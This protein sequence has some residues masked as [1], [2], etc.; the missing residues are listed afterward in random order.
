MKTTFFKIATVM[1][2]LI[3]GCSKDDLI[4]NEQ[5]SFSVEENN[6][7]VIYGE[8]GAISGDYSRG[9]IISFGGT[10][11]GTETLPVCPPGDLN[12]VRKLLINGNFSGNMKRFGKIVPSLSTYEISWVPEL[13]PLF[14]LENCNCPLEEEYRYKLVAHGRVALSDKDYF[15]ITIEGYL[16]TYETRTYRRWTYGSQFS[17]KASVDEGSGVGKFINFSEEFAVLTTS[18]SRTNFYHANLDTGVISFSISN[19]GQ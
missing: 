8:K 4:D 18:I 15:N 19:F 14:T 11:S 6:Q 10:S 12:C 16:N 7:P 9:S 2:L 1:L 17:G 3:F 13:N 5:E